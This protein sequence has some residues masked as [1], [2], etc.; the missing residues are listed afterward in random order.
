MTHLALPATEARRG[1]AVRRFIAR[2]AAKSHPALE[3]YR[4][5]RPVCPY[6]IAQS[7]F[8]SSCRYRFSAAAWLCRQPSQR[9]QACREC[10]AKALQCMDLSPARPCSSPAP[11]RTSL[12]S[13]EYQYPAGS[14]G[15]RNLHRGTA[16]SHRS[17][18]YRGFRHE[19]SA[20]SRVHR[21]FP[22]QWRS[23]VPAGVAGMPPRHPPSLPRE[24]SDFFHAIGEP[25]APPSVKAAERHHRHPPCTW[26]RGFHPLGYP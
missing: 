12:C 17:R 9:E 20:L 1:E 18:C 23:T 21:D 4:E 25:S 16:Q 8:C 5:Q 24:G 15:G 13:M 11:H 6:R 10:A 14:G 22:A 3:C 2:N 19:R 26:H 7:H